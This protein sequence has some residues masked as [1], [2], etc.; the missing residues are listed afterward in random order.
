MSAT[1]HL[2]AYLQQYTGGA[3]EVRVE[4]TTAAECLRHLVQ[5]FPDLTRMLF[6]SEGRLHDYVSV[7][8]NEQFA[9]GEELSRPVKDGDILHIL[10]ILGG[11]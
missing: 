8:V 2:P 5:Q 1:V 3:A 11:G 7:Y 4:G 10:Y 9:F 6:A